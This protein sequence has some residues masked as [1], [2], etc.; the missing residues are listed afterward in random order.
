MPARGKKNWGL[1]VAQ[2]KA[3]EIELETTFSTAGISMQ[4]TGRKIHLRWREGH[5]TSRELAPL[6][7]D[8]ADGA[9]LSAS[10]DEF[11]AKIIRYETETVARGLTLSQLYRGLLCIWMPS[12]VVSGAALALIWL[13]I[14]WLVAL[15]AIFG[16]RRMRY[17]KLTTTFKQLWKLRERIYF[18]L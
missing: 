15:E 7:E 8:I 1:P 14:W 18:A 10:V 16:Y 11:V 4:L 13:A 5:E 6:L 9:A 3:L 17:E 2:A 12:A